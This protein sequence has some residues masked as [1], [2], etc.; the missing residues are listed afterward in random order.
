M[1]HICSIAHDYSGARKIYA[2]RSGRLSHQTSKGLAPRG[3][4]LSSAVGIAITSECTAL[5][6][7]IKLPLIFSNFIKWEVLPKKIIIISFKM[8]Q[9]KEFRSLTNVCCLHNT[10]YR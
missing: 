9:F 7:K 1:E 4:V 6:E 8:H 10:V 3:A 2:P 5:N